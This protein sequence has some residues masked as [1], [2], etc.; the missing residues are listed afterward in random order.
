MAI[1]YIDNAIFFFA[2]SQTLLQQLVD[3]VDEFNQLAHVQANAAK[4][5]VL[6]LNTYN[7]SQGVVAL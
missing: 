2:W 6:A 1:E 7:G 5:F 3:L 4:G